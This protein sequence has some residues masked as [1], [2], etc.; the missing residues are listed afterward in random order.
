MTLRLSPIT[1]LEE[2]IINKLIGPEERQTQI[3]NSTGLKS[4]LSG[5]LEG[6]EREFFM[7]PKAG[8]AGSGILDKLRRGKAKDGGD[9]SPSGSVVDISAPSA[10]TTADD[11]SDPGRI[12]KMCVADM[13]GLW[14]DPWV[15][16][17][18]IKNRVRLEEGPGL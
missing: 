6:A 11:K 3:S 17:R 10:S 7:R 9:S 13:I 4:S 16:A 15:R 1:S 18:L 8:K 5:V 12:F 2:V 14:H